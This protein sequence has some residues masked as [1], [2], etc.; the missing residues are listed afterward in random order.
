MT[1]RA[2]PGLLHL[3]L[4]DDHAVV[5][6]GLKRILTAR[7]SQWHITEASSG[8]EA[9][10]ILRQQALDLAIVDLS[11]PGM[12]GLE[13]IHRIRA[14]FPS[15]MVLVLSMH[16]EEQ[17]AVRAFKSGAKGYVTKCTAAEELVAAV[18]KVAAGGAYV[19]TR[20]AER[21]VQQ[22]NGTLLD[23]NHAQLSNRELDI[24]Q[25][26]V[27]GQRLTDIATALHLS[28]K[29]VSTHKSHIQ[30]KLQL[31]ST[32]ALIRYGLEHQID[33]GDAGLSLDKT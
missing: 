8:F 27:A 31:P 16:A 1:E 22:F 5:R 24:L 30:E 17:Y 3:L 4:V 26:I 6:E 19:T 13:L 10:E 12:S 18:V 15:V 11:M 14:S 28:I 32:A 21:M 25:R 23:P 33:N 29:T 9:L 20:L 7:G 2:S